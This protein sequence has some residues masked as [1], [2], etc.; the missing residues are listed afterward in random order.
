MFGSSFLF[1]EIIEILILNGRSVIER[2]KENSNTSFTKKY[3]P[4]WD[5]R[6]SD[7]PDIKGVGYT[8]ICSKIHNTSLSRSIFVIGYN[9][10]IQSSFGVTSEA[11][12]AIQDWI[13]KEA[14]GILG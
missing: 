11:K 9:H 4:E 1:A 8:G 2:F 3:E 5:L 14:E 12:I 13:T 10:N 7:S 6:R